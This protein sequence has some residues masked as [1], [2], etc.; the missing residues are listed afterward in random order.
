[1]KSINLE[2]AFSPQPQRKNTTDP[3]YAKSTGACTPPWDRSDKHIFNEQTSFSAPGQYH[4]YTS[5]GPEPDQDWTRTVPAPDQDCARTR[6]DR[7][8]PA[9]K[10]GSHR[11]ESHDFGV[12]Y[13]N[14][15]HCSEKTSLPPQPQ[16][17]S[18]EKFESAHG[19]IG[20]GGKT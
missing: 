19:R 11:R 5:T 7:A 17:K 1:M 15:K 16:A 9:S 20:G 18:R 8:R 12:G 3:D 2:T 6:Q 14:S 10:R 13:E 4:D